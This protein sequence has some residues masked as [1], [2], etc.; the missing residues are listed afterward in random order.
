MAVADH[1]RRADL[2]VRGRPGLEKRSWSSTTALQYGDEEASKAFEK[3][4]GGEVE[5]RGGTAPSCTNVC[6]V[7]AT[8]RADVLVTTDLA[9]LWRAKDTGLLETVNTPTLRPTSSPLHDPDGYWWGLSTRL[10]ALIA[11]PSGSTRMQYQTYEDLGD[12]L[13]GPPPPANQRTSTTSPSSPTGSLHGDAHR[14]VAG[15]LD[16]QQPQILKLG[17]RGARRHR[18]RQ[19]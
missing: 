4:T 13:P 18:R 19:V 12:P 8:D 5:L 9:N 2:A 15:V 10:C 17:H 1:R 14:D 7:R 6:T 3:D 11:P 16:G